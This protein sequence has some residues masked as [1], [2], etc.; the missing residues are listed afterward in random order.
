MVVSEILVSA[1]PSMN[2]VLLPMF[3]PHSC[4]MIPQ[5]RVWHLSRDAATGSQ[6]LLANTVS[7]SKAVV[8]GAAIN[9]K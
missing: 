1:A 9:V 2:P 4:L 7:V 6:S 5:W 3:S 8:F